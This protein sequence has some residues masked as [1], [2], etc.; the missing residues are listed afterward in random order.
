VEE[1]VPL[2]NVNGKVLAKIIEYCKYHVEANKKTD[3]KPAKSEEDKRS[4]DTDFVKVDQATLF[5]LI[6]V[7]R[8]WAVASML[9]WP[10]APLSPG[11]SRWTGSTCKTVYVLD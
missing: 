8:S 10:L 6:L 3:E 5:D 4:W 1:I 9:H 2:P 11:A 7:R